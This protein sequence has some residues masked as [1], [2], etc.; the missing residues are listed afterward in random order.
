MKKYLLFVLCT[1]VLSWSIPKPMESIENYNVLLLHGAYGSKKGFLSEK[2]TNEAYFAGGS[3]ENGATLGGYT[4][5]ERITQWISSEMLEEQG[6]KNGMEYVHNSKVYNWRSF[7]NP[8]NS[9]K[10]NAYELGDRTWKMINDKFKHRR[11]L[12][13][14]AQEVKAF[15]TQKVVTDSGIRIDTTE[16]GQA[17]LE[18]IRKNP[19]L[20]R[21]LASRYILIGHSMGGVV[22]REYVQNSDYYYGDVDKVITL[23][24]PHEG[25][26]ALNMQLDMVDVPRMGIESISGSVLLMAGVGLS[27]YLTGKDLSA[28]TIGLTGLGLSAALS[29]MNLE[30]DALISAA[31]LEDYSRSDSLVCYVDPHADENDDCSFHPNITAL[32]SLYNPPDSLPMFRLMAGEHSMT[33]TDPKLGYK[34]LMSFYIPDALTT[35]FSNLISQLSSGFPM[36]NFNS[37]GSFGDELRKSL[38][39]SY[40]NAITGAVAGLVAGVHVHEQGSALVKTDG[41]LGFGTRMLT[42]PDVDVKR[43][44]FNAAYN[45][46]ETAMSHVAELLLV[47][48]SAAVALDYF[49][50]FGD[51]A[52]MALATTAVL[53]LEVSIGTSLT[54]GFLDLGNSHMFPLYKEHLETWRNDGS[55]T[56]SKIDGSIGG[57]QPYV[58]EDF[59]YERPFVNLALS[60]SRTMGLLAQDPSLNP[61][62]YFESDSLQKDPLCE[63]GV[64]GTRDSI[65]VDSVKKDTLHI[66][67]SFET[68]KYSEFRKSPLKFKSESDWYKV[69]V[70][71]D[72]WER[73]DGLHPDGSENRKGVP[74]RHVE[75][76]NVPDI[77]ATGFI[78]K[79]SFV[80]DD[81]MPHRMRQIKMTFNSIEEV[82][83]ECDI[84]KAEDDLQVFV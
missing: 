37:L 36:G 68:R 50:S 70:K 79:Y 34:K 74:I 24:S 67:G 75:R 7:S 27:A 52:K 16:K 64:Y 57:E 35:P 54:L 76:Y 1:V 60:D 48:G 20:F 81:L 31:F 21:K 6:W 66:Y 80:V 3:L 9:S 8:A 19:D 4:N 51:A 82:A 28:K 65:V 53:T 39:T 32:K 47:V 5:D 14:E 12:V 45:A 83:W 33:F 43:F 17:A 42:H 10:N 61:N 49:G 55:N 38:A 15:I 84:S 63:V 59:L 25:T 11:S 46:S 2:D 13:E 69:G 22:S 78:E 77:V 18:I 30:L 56:Y 72:R 26:G 40:V 71:V 58:M 44:K 29:T 41:G 62:C 23:D 73:V